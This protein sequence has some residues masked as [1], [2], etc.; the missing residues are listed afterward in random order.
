MTNSNKRQDFR[1]KKATASGLVGG[2]PELNSWTVSA[3]ISAT[4]WY[5]ASY[6]KNLKKIRD[7]EIEEVVDIYMKRYGLRGNEEKK[8]IKKCLIPIIKIDLM[9]LKPIEHEV[10]EK[11]EYLIYSHENKENPR[12]STKN[13]VEQLRN[14][15]LEENAKRFDLFLDFENSR[16]IV[17]GKPEDVIKKE[18][19]LRFLTLLLRNVGDSCTFTDLDEFVWGGKFVSSNLIWQTKDVV[20][21]ITDGLMSRYIEH[22][23]R[24]IIGIGEQREEIIDMDVYHIRKEDYK[25]NVLR[26][27]LIAKFIIT[28]LNS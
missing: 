3:V 18:R 23:T 11:Y 15:S 25:Y 24:R 28:H 17:K 22:G 4:E 27:C 19:P 14:L 21:E 10:Q 6:Y 13:E 12:K 20:C 9:K 16:L 8:E 2:I 1:G 26:Y 7:E 5:M